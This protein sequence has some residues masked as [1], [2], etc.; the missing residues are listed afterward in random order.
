MGAMIFAA[1]HDEECFPVSESDA[2]VDP[3]LV[4]AKMAD[5]DDTLAATMLFVV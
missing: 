4:L 1:D 2:A 5:D 3:V